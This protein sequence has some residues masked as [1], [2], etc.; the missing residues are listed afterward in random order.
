MR[1]SSALV[2]LFGTLECWRAGFKPVTAGVSDINGLTAQ[3]VAASGLQLAGWIANGI[4]RAMVHV[5]ENL[6][7]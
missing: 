3:A 6:A 4:D 7:T 1:D 5:E 2:Y